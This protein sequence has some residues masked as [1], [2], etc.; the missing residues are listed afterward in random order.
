[1]KGLVRKGLVAQLPEG[2]DIATH[3][4]PPY[5]PWDQRFCL[6]PDGDLFRAIR[7]GTA[8]VVTGSIETFTRKGIRLTSG[9]ELAAD[10]VV[11]ATGLQLQALGGV[12]LVVDGPEVALPSTVA[13]KGAMFSG[14]PNLASVFGYTNASW[15]LRADLISDWVCRLLDRM[16]ASGAD[17]V[18]A[19]W[20]GALPDRPFLDLTSGY[21]QRALATCRGRARRRRGASP[22]LPARPAAHG[23][24]APGL[25]GPAVLARRAAG[26]ADA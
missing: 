15:T 21:V 14:V 20:A 13:Y 4:T 12:Q 8:E 9:E 26:G 17:T 10:V 11:T 1:M 6:V 25:R 19:E 7:H 24:R 18:V 5:D 3:F 23:P 2:Y 16:R 22:G